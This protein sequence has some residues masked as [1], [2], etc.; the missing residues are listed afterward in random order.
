MSFLTDYLKNLQSV[1]L[2]IWLTILVIG[3]VIFGVVYVTM[4]YITKH[5]HTPNLNWNFFVKILLWKALVQLAVFLSGKISKNPTVVREIGN[6]VDMVY[7]VYI[8]FYLLV[9]LLTMKKK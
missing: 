1:P 5:Y 8:A 2:K 3:F 9:G 6:V 7:L 4:T